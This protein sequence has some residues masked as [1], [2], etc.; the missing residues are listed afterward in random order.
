MYFYVYRITCHHSQST[1]KYYYGVCRCFHSPVEDTSY[2][3]SSRYIAQARN[4]FGS[5]W[6]EKKIVSL[7]G[8]WEAALAKEIRFHAYFDVLRHPLFFNRAN[9]TTLSFKA[10]GQAQ[11][12]E[13]FLNP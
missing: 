6:F 5:E 8:T 4:H 1:E 9:Q 12:E 13:R 11:F 7:H 2:W 3:S 10:A